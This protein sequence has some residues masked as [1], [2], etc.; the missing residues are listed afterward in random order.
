MEA[1]ISERSAWIGAGALVI[2]AVIAGA[3]ALYVHTHPNNKKSNDDDDDDQGS[4]RPRVAAYE[5]EVQPPPSSGDQTKAFERREDPE[6]RGDPESREG[7]ERRED[8]ERRDDPERM[9]ESISEPPIPGQKPVPEFR[10]KR[11]REPIPPRVPPTT[12]PV[13]PPN[14]T[15]VVVEPIRDNGATEALKADIRRI[16]GV[17][18][19]D[20][21]DLGATKEFLAA[22][23]RILATGDQDLAC[24]A[25]NAWRR[26]ASADCTFLNRDVLE[27][28]S[29]YIDD[30]NRLC[31]RKVVSRQAI[32]R[33]IE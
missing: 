27:G 4:G 30:L 13:P 17:I 32:E 6:S 26:Y 16:H 28:A 5:Q 23:P 18:E 20:P 10:A 15:A 12:Q 31:A 29:Q 2:A 22:M 14:T 1:R 9:G 24:F 8:P 33:C 25:A 21:G 19:F 11:P 7:P 3:V